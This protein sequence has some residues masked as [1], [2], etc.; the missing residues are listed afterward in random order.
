MQRL[1][2]IAVRRASING[3]APAVPFGNG[4]ASQQVLQFQRGGEGEPRMT[5]VQAM[6][7][8]VHQKEDAGH[9]GADKTRPRS[10]AETW[11]MVCEI[12]VTVWAAG[13]GPSKTRV[14]TDLSC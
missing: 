14:D 1:T 4:V 7:Q 5:G 2:V 6:F 12:F 13:T 3:D 10:L 11:Q 9:A 8:E